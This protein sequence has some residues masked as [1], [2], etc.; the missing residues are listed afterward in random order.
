MAAGLGACAPKVGWV[1]TG[2]VCEP[3]DPPMVCLQAEPDAPI[4]MRVG[5]V[6]LLP[7]ECAQGPREEGGGSTKIRIV[8]GRGGAVK[9]RVRLPE[10]H[11]T[12]ITVQPE[13]EVDVGRTGCNQRPAL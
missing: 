11:A 2:R 8:D 1:R 6:T 5:D 10:G 13:L 4:E 7:G 12:T 9:K 3:S